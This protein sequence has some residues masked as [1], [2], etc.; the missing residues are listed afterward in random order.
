MSEPQALLRTLPGP[1]SAFAPL[2]ALVLDSLSSEHSRR[3]YRQAL[4]EFFAWYE[5]NA[6]GGGFT[7]ATV[8][9][10]RLDLESRALAPSSMNLR[11][12]LK[13]P[14]QQQGAVLVYQYNGIVLYW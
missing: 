2:P 8:Q 1:A 9:R 7:K 10:H 11:S 4:E 5:G 13:F 3:A 12:P 6:A 14:M